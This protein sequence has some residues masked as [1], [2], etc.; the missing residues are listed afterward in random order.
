MGMNKHVP[1]HKLVKDVL[2]KDFAESKT[3]RL[4][5]LLGRGGNAEVYECSRISDNSHFAVG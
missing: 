3:Y 2:V 5:A 1:K 4:G